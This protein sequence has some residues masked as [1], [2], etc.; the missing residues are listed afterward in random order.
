VVKSTSRNAEIKVANKRA[1][2][3]FSVND[4]RQK[5]MSADERGGP[6]LVSK[7]PNNLRAIALVGYM[8][9]GKTTVGAALAERLNWHFK[10]VDDLIRARE[11]CGIEQLFQ[12]KGELAFRDIE[13][14]TLCETISL[15][16][17]TPTVLALGGGAFV[18]SRNHEILRAGNIPAVFLDAPVDE[19]FRRCEQ[20]GV[21]RPLRRNVAQFSELYRQRR[22]A[23]QKADF[24]IATAGKEIR[25][26]VEEIV[27]ELKLAPASGVPK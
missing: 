10:D 6:P 2:V 7:N 15:M 17:S 18:E 3:G 11:G 19:L 23:Y 14:Q 20:P 24:S 25:A 22:P 9:A 13:H 26:I 12:Q 4:L 27:K 21:S 16:N 5:S 8:G 1:D